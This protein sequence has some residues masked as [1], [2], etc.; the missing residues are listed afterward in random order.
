M[1]IYKNQLLE[2]LIQYRNSALQTSM[3]FY[4][5]DVFFGK[6]IFELKSNTKSNIEFEFEFESESE[7][8]NIDFASNIESK[9]ESKL[10]KTLFEKTVF[11]I[12][13]QNSVNFFAIESI[14]SNDVIEVD[15]NDH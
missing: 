12:E 9:S 2:K 1:K 7:S 8:K 15:V 14:D 13:F 5:A 10:K 11:E 3:N 4:H 6:I